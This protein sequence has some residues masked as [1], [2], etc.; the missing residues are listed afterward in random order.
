MRKT[1][2]K[3]VRVLM[4]GPGRKVKGGISSVVNSYYD[5][6]LHNYVELTYLSTMQDGS[7]IKKFVVA[8]IAYLRFSF[9][10][11]SFDII[12]IHMAAQASFSRKAI[13]IKKA[14]KVGK[15][16]IIHQHAAD[17]DVYLKNASDKKKEEIR[18]IFTLADKVIT[19]SEEWADFFGQNVCKRSS[20]L[21]L[22]NGVIIPEYEK[23][24]Y[25]D[26]CVLFLGRLGK[27]K[28]TYDL[29]K[30]IPTVL[31]KVPDVV[32]YLGGD[33]EIEY[34]KNVVNEYK[35]TENVRFL[36]WLNYDDKV[37][38]FKKCSTFILPS[39]HE[40]M[41]MA[42]LEA[43][44]YGLATISTNVGG[45]PQI[46]NCNIDGIRV[47]AGNVDAISTAILNVINNL[48]VKRNLGV[49]ARERV[50]LKFNALENIKK[51]CMIYHELLGSDYI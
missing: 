14:H 7:V 2:E 17:F 39:Y 49:K 27:R 42:V 35:I 26:H 12:H 51:I 47:E 50:A 5:L 11:K 33:G 31:R 13:F 18:Y 21:V 19:L 34:S 8:M 1:A 37:K 16:I 38:Y 29:L 20:I 15:K 24:D 22:Y 46:I 23:L 41:P 36:G 9:I 45:I 32:F 6:G 44:S 28:G 4:V 3:K 10:V 25:S 48:E 43:M 40:G 30:A